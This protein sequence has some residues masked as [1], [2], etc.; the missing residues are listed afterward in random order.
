MSPVYGKLDFIMVDSMPWWSE[1]KP[2][3]KTALERGNSQPILSDPVTS[4]IMRGVFAQKTYFRR[5]NVKSKP[6]FINWMEQKNQPYFPSLPVGGILLLAGKTDQEKRAISEI[7]HKYQERYN[8]L[9]SDMSVGYSSVQEFRCIINMHGFTP[10][11]VP[12]ETK[13]WSTRKADTKWF[14]RYPKTHIVDMAEVLME[15]KPKNCE[16]FF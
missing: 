15:K 13:H 6:L 3:I 2:M 4:T 14:Y 1:W 12:A 7:L 8:A 16:V 10:T 5:I 11:W 9:K